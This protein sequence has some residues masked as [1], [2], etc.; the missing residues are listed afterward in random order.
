[1]TGD[2]YYT[3]VGDPSGLEDSY[4]LYDQHVLKNPSTLGFKSVVEYQL[5]IY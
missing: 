2:F 1:M 4:D 3:V 5:Y